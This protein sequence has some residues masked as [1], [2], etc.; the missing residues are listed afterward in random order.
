MIVR[1]IALKLSLGRKAF[2]SLMGLALP[3]ASYAQEPSSLPD[4]LTDA[5]FS[6]CVTGLQEKARAA[7]ISDKTNNEILA[8]SRYLTNV[9]GYD[10]N[11][12]EFVQTFPNY[13]RKRVNDWRIN[14]GR[15]MLA[16]HRELLTSLTQKYGIP[17]HYLV[18]FWGLET[19]FGAYKGKMPIIDSLATLAC[20]QRRSEFFTKELMLALQLLERE[21]LTTDV[22][23][24]SWAGAMGHTQFMP[25]AYLQYAVDGDG[26]NRI[27]LWESEQDALTSAANFLQNLGWKTGFKWGREV[28]LKD[29]FDYLLAGKDKSFELSFWS[30][31]G[32]TKTDG[33]TLGDSDLK[34]SL[35]LPAG[36][37][38]PAF[39]VYSNFDVIMRWNNSESYALAVGY[40]ADRITGK[41]RLSRALPDMPDYKV[42]ALRDLQIALNSLGFDV[43]E[44]DGI[45]GPATR[46]GIRQFQAI[47]QLI[48]DGFPDQKLFD[49]VKQAFKQ[50]NTTTL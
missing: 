9:I 13:M 14:K 50:Q 5:E 1:M 28:A 31:K 17:A 11:Q 2:F 47:N 48:A 18:S 36:H 7:G 22:M 10:R 24:G 6:Q 30:E 26:D 39:L 20:D 23:V 37:K 12:P 25:S 15:E 29:D 35:L 43:G 19:N 45:Y 49:A 32:V 34:A 40:L 27:N 33:S 4:L 42:D 16:K 3:L 44:A 41:P 21:N 8:K 46:S 38:G